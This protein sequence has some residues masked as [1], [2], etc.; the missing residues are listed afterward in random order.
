MPT[1]PLST[2][3]AQV[4]TSHRTVK[5]FE[6]EAGKVAEFARAITDP[7]PVFFD[8]QTARDRGHDRIPAPL[9]FT[10]VGTFPRYA[11]EDERGFDLGFRPE[12]V[13]HGEQ[14]YE[15]DRP[16]YVGDVLEGTTT[17]TDCYQREGGRG[18]TMTFA[19]FE[20]TYTDQDGDRVLTERTTSIETTGAIDG[21][22]PSTD[23]QP[24]ARM[25]EP[26]PIRPRQTVPAERIDPDTALAVG[27][28]GP[29]IV[30]EDLHRQ[31]FVRYAGASGDF[32]PI[33]YDEPYATAAGNERVFGQGMFTA[34]VASRV[35]TDWFGID[36]IA[37]FSVRFRSRVFPGDTIV[38]TGEVVNIG[39]NRTDVTVELEATADGKT[40][41]TGTATVITE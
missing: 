15:Y 36:R 24:P 9:T 39:S 32:N 2:L 21:D 4:G 35:L 19:V 7:N 28:T 20:T 8:A 29:T 38:G 33:H 25:M 6:I 3:E 34:G 41:L 40:L 17:L 12:H 5:G 1:K 31:D 37:S 26:R 18:G 11:V 22:G 30:V 27:D 10:R 16:V 23:R 14:S 13:I